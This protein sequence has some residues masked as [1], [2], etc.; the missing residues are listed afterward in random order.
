MP[1]KSLSIQYIAG[2]QPTSRYGFR[3]GECLGDDA[4][5]EMT[6][7][8]LDSGPASHL[9]VETKGQIESSITRFRMLAGQRSGALVS[10]T[11]HSRAR[12]DML[13]P[14]GRQLATM[15]SEH[16]LRRELQYAEPR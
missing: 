16:E 15:T 1:P 4:P 3:L 11:G 2:Y 13:V 9:W 10:K 5:I 14:C 12:V 6:A 8:F 7:G